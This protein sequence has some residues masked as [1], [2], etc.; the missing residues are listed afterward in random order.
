MPNHVHLLLEPLQDESLCKL[1]KGIKGASARACNQI[2]NQTGNF[3]MEESY[4]H[5]V[6]NREEY[7][8]FIRYIEMNPVKAK[9]RA[10]EYDFLP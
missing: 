3:W 7:T 10:D 9:L 5:I 6:R 2:L 4:D 8:H 1:M